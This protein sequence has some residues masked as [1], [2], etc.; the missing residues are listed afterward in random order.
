MSRRDLIRMSTEEAVAFLESE[1][2]LI[3]A[4]NG[5]DGWPHLMPLWYVLREA[6][7]DAALPCELW[8]WTY[9]ASQKV[10]NVERDP[11]VTIAVETGEQYQELR[12]VMLKTRAERHH[13]L[14][15][16]RGVGEQLFQRYSGAAV[17]DDFKQV[18][19]AQAA[20]RVALRFVAESLATWDHRKL[21]GVY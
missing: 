14:D 17:G 9:A 19:E 11:H 4:T 8:G 6:A 12:G 5:P 21:G 13:E 2:V 16:V 1:R 15:V 3:C 18:V 10:R 20:K 7:G